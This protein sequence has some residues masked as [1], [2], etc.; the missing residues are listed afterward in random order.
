[1]IKICLITK[2]KFYKK[3]N[4]LIS[5]GFLW[6]EESGI[7]GFKWN[8]L[9]KLVLIGFNEKKEFDGYKYKLE[10]FKDLKII[11]PEFKEEERYI[12]DRL[13]NIF[14][15][16]IEIWKNRKNLKDI[17]LV[18]APFF[19]YIIFK[20]ILL[21][22]VCRRAKFV[23]YI[24]GDYPELNYQKNK[25]YFLKIFLI[26]LMKLSQLLA[27]KVWFL[28]KYLHK[29]YTMK[30]S[31]EA[32]IPTSSIRFSEI[33]NSKKLDSNLIKILFV[34]RFAKEKNPE[35]PIFIGSN[36]ISKGCN[37]YLGLIGDGELFQTIEDLCKKN[38]PEDKYK[39]YGWIKDRN[40]LLKIVSD[41]DFLIFPSKQGEG[42]GLVIVEAISQGLVVL[43]TKCGGPEEIIEDNKNGFLIDL[44]EKDLIK[45]FVEKIEFLINNPQEFEKISKNNIEK[46]KNWTMEKFLEIQ[47]K[48]I[49]ELLNK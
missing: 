47:R 35:I 8:E 33:G 36:L 16:L 25:N 10:N 37:I 26:F 12:L 2:N 13:I 45:R 18:F 43:A 32:V 11:G 30:S 7:L 38:L 17:D 23:L 3:D 42:L 1:M 46:A 27:D 48:E 15:T 40:D 39:L 4:E 44:D 14:K 9:D 28:S 21:K 19:E 20:F 5:S 41:Y 6:Y 22:I 31:K 49:L 29:R 34:G 24:I